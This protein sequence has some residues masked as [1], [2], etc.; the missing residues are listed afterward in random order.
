MSATLTATSPMLTTLLG[1]FDLQTRLFKNAT[2][3]IS[4]AHASKKPNEHTNHI[5]WLAGHVVSTRFMLANMLGVPAKEPFPALFENGKGLD[6]KVAY[7]SMND[8]R[9]DWETIS[10][11]MHNALKKISEDQLY[12]ELPKGLPMGKRMID[13]IGFIA[14]H[15]GYTIG[16]LGFLRRFHGYEAMKY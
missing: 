5:A 4:D 10:A 9:K 2:E 8:L 6:P 7:P 12:A 16:Q 11:S 14:H 13:F 3:G 15:E 1:Q